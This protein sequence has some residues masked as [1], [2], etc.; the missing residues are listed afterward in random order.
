MFG[1]CATGRAVIVTA[2]TITM[3][4]EMTMATIGQLMK[5]LDTGQSP[6][7]GWA[8]LIFTVEPFC[9]FCS[10]STITSSPCL[11]PL[12]TIQSG[13]TRSATF[14]A[15]MLTLQLPRPMFVGVGQRG[16]SRSRWQTQVPKFSF[17]RGQA[18]A[19]FTQR[20]GVPQLT[21]KHGNELTPATETA[22]M[23]FRFVLAYRRFK[24]QARDQLQNLLAS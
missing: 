22:G 10:P 20:L 8:C 23:T 5:N 16:A 11:T 1:N 14:I 7:A 19:A 17:T 13:P 15:R 24:F 12:S 21:K 2:P 4:M 9:T 6:F 18:S 3:R